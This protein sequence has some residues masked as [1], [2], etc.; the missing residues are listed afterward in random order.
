MIHV[1]YLAKFLP[2]F[3]GDDF[4]QDV[5]LL[6]DQDTEKD[7]DFNKVT[8]MTVHAAKGLE[9]PYVFV[10]ELGVHT[11]LP[12]CWEHRFPSLTLSNLTPCFRQLIS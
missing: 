7:N 4:M 12:C 2:R 6:T 11:F 9:F 10:V 8:M 5:A 1:I 3:P